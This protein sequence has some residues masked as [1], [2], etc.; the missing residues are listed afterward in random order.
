M[1]SFGVRPPRH[2][3]I[4]MA[5]DGAETMFLRYGANCHA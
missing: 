2:R 3:A 4:R 1:M 5:F